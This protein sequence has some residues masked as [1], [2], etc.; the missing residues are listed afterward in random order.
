MKELRIDWLGSCP[1]C[2]S[3]NHIVKTNNGTRKWLYDGDEVNCKCG[4]TGEIECDDGVAW[5]N[6]EEKLTND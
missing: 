1:T 6:W 3:D 5:V 4:Q 2:E